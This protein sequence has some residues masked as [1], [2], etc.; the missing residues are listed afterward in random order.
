MQLFFFAVSFVL[1]YPDGNSRT[2][3]CG[4]YLCVVPLYRRKPSTLLPVCA[5]SFAVRQKKMLPLTANSPVMRMISRSTNVAVGAG[6]GGRELLTCWNSN[7]AARY[8]NCVPGNL[9]PVPRVQRRA[10]QLVIA[11]RSL[12]PNRGG[13]LCVQQ[14]LSSNIIICTRVALGYTKYQLKSGVGQ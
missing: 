1:P 10:G 14:S 11:E 8:E 2:R 5:F 3:I 13:V 4:R 7:P 6:G 9:V 12:K